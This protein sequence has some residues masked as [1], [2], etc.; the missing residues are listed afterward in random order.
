LNVPKDKVVQTLTHSDSTHKFIEY[1]LWSA[2]LEERQKGLTVGDAIP[3]LQTIKLALEVMKSNYIHLIS[4][5]DLAI[6]FVE[7]A[8]IANAKSTLHDLSCGTPPNACDGSGIIWN[9]SDYSRIP[10]AQA[11]EFHF[12][13]MVMYSH[14]YSFNPHTYN[15]T[16]FLMAHKGGLDK[17]LY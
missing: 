17:R 13:Y 6:K 10:L 7:K 2:Q 3:N 9:P 8:Y 12:D 16:I 14:Q 1:L 15:L 5:R 4:N 11:G